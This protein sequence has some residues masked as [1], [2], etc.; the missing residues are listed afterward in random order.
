MIPKYLEKGAAIGTVMAEA[1]AMGMLILLSR[2]YLKK[3]NFFSFQ[4]MKYFLASIVMGLIIILIKKIQL[5]I[6]DELLLSIF[7][8]GFIYF[9]SLFLMKESYLIETWKFIKKDNN[10]NI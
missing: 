5:K 8:G 2:K 4:R 10:K 1:I 6:M 9:L 7:G 3:I